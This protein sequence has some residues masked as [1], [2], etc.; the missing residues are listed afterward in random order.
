MQLFEF[1]EPFPFCPSL[2]YRGHST[3]CIPD[4]DGLW[5]ASKYISDLAFMLPGRTQASQFLSVTHGLYQVNYR[6][7][8]GRDKSVREKRDYDNF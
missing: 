3:T 5:M 7:I 6:Q 1:S 2:A 8:L 4:L